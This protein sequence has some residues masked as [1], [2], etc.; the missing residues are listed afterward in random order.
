MPAMAQVGVRRGRGE[1]RGEVTPAQRPRLERSRGDRIVAGVAAGIGHHLGI[2]PLTV[3]IAFVV[4]SAAAGFG[5][6]V[7][8]LAWLLTPEEATEAPA[9]ARPRSL[10]HPT[11]RQSLGAL[12]ILV[13][14]V[15]LL[16][17]SGFWSES[18]EGR[19]VDVA[20]NAANPRADDM[21]CRQRRRRMRTS[22]NIVRRRGRTLRS[23]S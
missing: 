13:G 7:Y 6:V 16:Y 19:I 1:L 17:V 18:L 23:D 5:I 22:V 14:V 20:P 21:S 10:F 15:L 8:L 11:M 9:P 12:L 4:L 2:E 3:R